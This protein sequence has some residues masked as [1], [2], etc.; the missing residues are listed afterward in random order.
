VPDL[1][2]LGFVAPNEPSIVAL[3]GL[4]QTLRLTI[5]AG[6]DAHQNVLPNKASDG[7]R[8][9]SY[10]RMIRWFNNRVRLDGELTPASGQGGAAGGAQPH[11]VRG[12]RQ[13][14]GL[15]LRGQ[16]KGEVRLPRWGP[17]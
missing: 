1:A 4:G 15:R 12:V 17:S 5:S 11:R 14:A 13:P 9:D 10:R 7:E 2:P 16:Y 3:E 6:T 8:I